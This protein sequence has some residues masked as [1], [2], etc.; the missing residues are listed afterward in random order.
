MEAIEL[1]Q[2][3][4]EKA[5]DQLREWHAWIEHFKFT[6]KGQDQQQC[7]ERL[8]EYHHAARAQLTELRACPDDRWELVKQAVERAMIELKR[9][10]DEVGVEF[11][12]KPIQL[13]QR[14]SYIYEPFARKG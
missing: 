13:Q 14:R 1:K 8:E 2:A 7:V 12:G 3:Y 11:V 10:M 9:V 5:D 4:Q 6:S